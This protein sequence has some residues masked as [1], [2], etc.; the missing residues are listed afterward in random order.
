MSLAAGVRATQIRIIGKGAVAVP[1]A[2]MEA[3]K[4]LYADGAWTKEEVQKH[5]QHPDRIYE[6]GL[7]FSIIN[8]MGTMTILTAHGIQKVFGLATDAGRK[9]NAVRPS[10]SVTSQFDTAYVRLSLKALGWTQVHKGR[11]HK[12]APSGRMVEVDTPFGEALL[13]GKLSGGYTAAG[14]QKVIEK[15]RSQALYNE[16]RVVILTPSPT[17]GQRIA[18]NE[19]AW[20]KV[21]SICPTQD[22]D[23]PRLQRAVGWGNGRPTPVRQIKPATNTEVL[24]FEQKRDEQFLEWYGSIQMQ[25]KTELIRRA[26]LA[27]QCDGVLARQQLER[28]YGLSPEDLEGWPYIEALLRPVH[29]RETL[30]VGTWFFLSEEAQQFRSWTSLAH[31][32][33]TADMRHILDVEPNSLVWRTRVSAQ[34]SKRKPDAVWFRDEGRVAIET[35]TATYTRRD[36]DDKISA[37]KDQGYTD[38]I[39]GVASKERQRRIQGEHGIRVILAGWH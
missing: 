31:D 10:I 36:V 27:L 29:S 13:I 28:Y 21:V 17:R 14:I 20:L 32:A 12:Y 5:L 9:A 6:A 39:W 22:N 38:I 16:F 19:S 1:H 30:Q 24:E 3:L 8:E 15:F 23:P 7:I 25:D 11:L 34:N 4:L 33:S 26:H 35:D 18:R 37:F 2:D